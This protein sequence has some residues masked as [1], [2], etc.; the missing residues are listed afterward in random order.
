MELQFQKFI[1]LFKLIGL[2]LCFQVFPLLERSQLEIHGTFYLF[3]TILFLF[4]PVVYLTLPETKD[5][6]LELVHT[7]FTPTKTVFYL[8]V[9]P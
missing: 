8:D 7:Y 1:V 5:I 3:G 6:A 9:N 4:M 2:F